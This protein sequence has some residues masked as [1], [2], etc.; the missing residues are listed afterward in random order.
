[1]NFGL[2]QGAFDLEMSEEDN[3]EG[4]AGSEIAFPRVYQMTVFS[5]NSGRLSIVSG[6]CPRA[7][8]IIL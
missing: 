8:S 5:G 3:N 7:H 1:M 4:E 6:Y 2:A